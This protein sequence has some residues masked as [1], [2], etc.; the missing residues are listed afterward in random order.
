MCLCDVC[1]FVCLCGCGCLCH[2]VLASCVNS[3]C[4]C[5][6]TMYMYMHT[7]ILANRYW[8]CP[9]IPRCHGHCLDDPWSRTGQESTRSAE[10]ERV[11]LPKASADNSR[12]AATEHQGLYH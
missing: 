8:M 3:R 7:A 1:V 12:E 2:M 9:W 10:R 5:N 6:G 4:K 11:H